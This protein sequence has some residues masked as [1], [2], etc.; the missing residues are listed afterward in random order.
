MQVMNCVPIRSI[1]LKSRWN[2]DTAA[3]KVDGDL[4]NLKD[5]PLVEAGKQQSTHL[6]TGPASFVLPAVISAIGHYVTQRQKP[7]IAKI[8]PI[9]GD[10]KQV[11]GVCILNG[12]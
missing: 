8:T 1:G 7:I 4:T 3:S 2:K 10:P 6:M 5:W 9:N 11:G 12:T